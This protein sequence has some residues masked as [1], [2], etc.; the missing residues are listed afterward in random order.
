M[1][2][3]K[4]I[5]NGLAPCSGDSK[6]LKILPLFEYERQWRSVSS[7]FRGAVRKISIKENVFFYNRNL[8]ARGKEIISYS[9]D[10]NIFGS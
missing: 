1:S 7:K 4:S 9:P 5:T 8:F 10:N 6:K 3:W 2:V